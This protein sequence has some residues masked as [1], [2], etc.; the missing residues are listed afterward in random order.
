MA[1]MIPHY[2]PNEGAKL[3]YFKKNE[4]EEYMTAYKVKTQD[5]LNQIANNY[6]TKKNIK[7]D[8]F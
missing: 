3:L 5:E 8:K 6:I 7:N 1:G 2:K 4:I